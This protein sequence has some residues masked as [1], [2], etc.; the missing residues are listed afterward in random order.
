MSEPRPD[1]IAR[2][3]VDVGAMWVGFTDWSAR[4]APTTNLD[5]LLVH[6]VSLATPH[7]NHVRSRESPLQPQGKAQTHFPR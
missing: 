4:A 1:D 5:F 6:T 7:S 3:D 2:I